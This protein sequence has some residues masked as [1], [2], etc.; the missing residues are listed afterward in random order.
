VLQVIR[1]HPPKLVFYDPTDKYNTPAS[2][3][4]AATLE[5]RY[6]KLVGVPPFEVFRARSAGL[7]AMEENHGGH[8]AFVRSCARGRRD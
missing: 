5:T 8:P 2:L 1:C 6:E 7:A 4:I 3:R